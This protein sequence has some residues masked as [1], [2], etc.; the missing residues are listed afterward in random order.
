MKNGA[1][2]GKIL[3]AGGGGHMMFLCDPDKRHRIVKAINKTNAKI[4][5]FN[6]DISGLQTWVVQNK[7]VKNE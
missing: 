2:G 6:F 4:V 5:N 3:G 7:R 1:L